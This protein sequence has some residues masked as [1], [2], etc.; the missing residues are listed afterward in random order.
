MSKIE[1]FLGDGEPSEELIAAYRKPVGWEPGIEGTTRVCEICKHK[2]VLYRESAK[3]GDEGKARL[4]CIPC[5]RK[6]VKLR[7]EKGKKRV[8]MGGVIHGNEFDFN[9]W[10]KE[11]N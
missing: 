3:R 5:F 1:Y 2:I 11:N 4:I 8:L 10:K 9:A 6:I 7:E